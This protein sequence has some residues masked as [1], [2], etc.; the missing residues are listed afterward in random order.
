MEASVII[1]NYEPK[2]HL[3][4]CVEAA[5]AQ[6][7]AGGHFEVVLPVHGELTE[8]DLA[9]LTMVAAR[10]GGRL[11]VLPGPFSDRCAAL[12]AACRTANG[13]VLIFLES[14][15]S[16][17]PDLARALIEAARAPGTAAVQGAF[18]T[19][20]V[21][22]WVAALENQLRAIAVSRRVARGQWP[23]EWH[24]H[25]AAVPRS[26]FLAAGGFHPA[27][28]DISEVLLLDQLSRFHGTV[29]HLQEPAVTHINHDD[30]SHYA[31]ALQRRGRGVGQ[32][33][34]L[35]PSAASTLFP[36]PAWALEVR[37]RPAAR[38]AARFV[39]WIQRHLFTATVHVGRIA[40]NDALM[41]AAGTRAVTAAIRAGFLQ[42]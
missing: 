22:S 9:H 42:R 33:W 7:L 25:S 15:V 11:R 1:S 35:D 12:N 31:R 10:S 20:E 6:D 4:A 8:A 16:A 5:L 26:T 17:P 23:D 24:L 13:R 36:V 21:G 39:L 28:T 40:G 27:L 41:K 38:H 18:V 2:G 14:H 3:R 30:W 32:L 19:R 37:R 34:D 29:V